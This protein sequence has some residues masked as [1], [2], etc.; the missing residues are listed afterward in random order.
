MHPKV[1]WTIIFAYEDIF[2][3]ARKPMD[4]IDLEIKTK[5]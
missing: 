3:L 4:V 5:W 2:W 1:I